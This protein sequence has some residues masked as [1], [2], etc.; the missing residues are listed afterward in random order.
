[1]VGLLALCHMATPASAAGTATPKSLSAFR[2]VLWHAEIRVGPKQDVLIGDL[3]YGPGMPIEFGLVGSRFGD[4]IYFRTERK[5]IREWEVPAPGQPD[6]AMKWAREFV[7]RF[8]ASDTL[9][10]EMHDT[11]EPVF[12]LGNK[13][14]RMSALFRRW[15]A[16]TFGPADYQEAAALGVP[17]ERLTGPPP[18]R[19]CPLDR[20]G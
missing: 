3:F 10:V 13:A 17:V 4:R 14:Q 18:E 16:E 6:E 9:F 12:A 5:I 8:G 15:V 19:L 7:E 20:G 2:N 1:M 11:G